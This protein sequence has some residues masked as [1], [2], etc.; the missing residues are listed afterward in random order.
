MILQLL[1]LLICLYPW[2]TLAIVH[3]LGTISSLFIM[4]ERGHILPTIIPICILAWKRA[5]FCWH[6]ISCLNLNLCILIEMH[7]STTNDKN[8]S[9]LPP[10][11]PWPCM[12]H[13]EWKLGTIFAHNWITSHFLLCDSMDIIFAPITDQVKIGP[14]SLWPYPIW[15]MF[16]LPSIQPRIK[17][18]DPLWCVNEPWL[19]FPLHFLW[20]HPFASLTFSILHMLLC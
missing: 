4:F 16:L 8:P 1:N 7:F 19:D 13:F 15:A 10:T 17:L 18:F 6:M 20:N 11:K 14:P 3:F 9:L 2:R 5:Y 12:R